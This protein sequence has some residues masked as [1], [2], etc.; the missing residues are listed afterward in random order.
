VWSRILGTPAVNRLI[1]PGLV[2]R[3]MAARGDH[4]RRIA[5]EVRARAGTR[6]G[7]R[8]SAGLWRSF[9]DPSYDLL[10]RAASITVPAM[11]MWGL[12]DP[13][14]PPGAGEQT[15]AAIPGATLRTFDTGHVVFAS[16]PEGFTD[17]LLPFIDASYQ[18]TLS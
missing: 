14:F 5:A 16:D 8:L 1:Y 18:R 11:V 3:Y 6:G 12:R 17:A 7:A 15:A 2:P 4:D 13:V 9:G 10:P